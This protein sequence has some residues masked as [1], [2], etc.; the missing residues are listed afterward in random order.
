MADRA[1]GVMLGSS[2]AIARWRRKLN[3]AQQVAPTEPSFCR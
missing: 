3:L 2:V 1:N